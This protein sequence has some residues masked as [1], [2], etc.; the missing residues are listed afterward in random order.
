MAFRTTKIQSVAAADPEALYRQIAKT[1]A[2]PAYLW[3]HQQELLLGWHEHFRGHENVALELPT[4]AGKTLVGGLI[5]EWIRREEHKP[6]AYLCPTRQLAKQAHEKLVSYGISAVDLTGKSS[7]WPPADRAKFTSAQSVAVATYSHVFNAYP[8]IRDTGTLIFD[9]AHAGASYVSS[10][11]TVS[12]PR[13]ESLYFTLLTALSAGLDSATVE[14]LR[15]DGSS[16][17]N[18]GSVYLVSPRA[19]L[20]AQPQLQAAIAAD[21][22]KDRGYRTSMIGGN[23]GLCMV[24]ASHSKLEIR[25]LI[26]PTATH[27]AFSSPQRR[28]FMSATLGEGGELERSFGVPDIARMPIPRGWDKEG[29]GRRFFVFPA[30]T[31]ELNDDPDL[32]APWVK[33]TV[34]VHGRTALLTP[35]ATESSN[36]LEKSIP[37][38]FT[39]LSGHTVENDMAIFTNDEK[40]ILDLANRY[41]G[42]DLPNEACRLVILSGLP[43][44]S[45]L[46]EKFQYNSLG[47]QNVLQERIRTRL[48]QGMGRATRNQHDFSTVVVL[49]TELTN[50]MYR[51]EVLQA[52]REEIQAEI[53]FGR[54]E[55][56]GRDIADVNEN[57]AAFLAQSEAWSAVNAQI[58]TDRLMK[59]RVSPHGTAELA[60]AASYEVQAMDA[61]WSGDLESALRQ[62]RAVLDELARNPKTGRYA[63]LW[64]L[65]ACSWTQM[66]ADQRGDSERSLHRA[67]VK[68]FAN[69]REHARGT[70]WFR[71]LDPEDQD[72]VSVESYDELDRFAAAQIVDRIKAKTWG[73]ETRDQL[74]QAVRGLNQNSYKPFEGGLV[75]LGMLAGASESFG[76]NGEQAAPDAVWIFG[77]LLWVAWEAKSEAKPGGKVPAR[78][79][80]EASS[81]LT[82]TATKRTEEAPESSFICYVTPQTSAD[83]GA[84]AVAGEDVFMLPLH[85]PSTL[86]ARLEK[87]WTTARAMGDGVEVLTVLQALKQEGCLPSQWIAHYMRH[88]LKYFSMESVS[89]GTKAEVTPDNVQESTPA[90]AKAESG[91]E[92]G[93]HKKKA[94]AS[95]SADPKAPA[96]SPQDSPPNK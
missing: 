37:E 91:S 71:H 46:Q 34:E 6:V 64:F 4:G 28:I 27:D 16:L 8:K 1:N 61:L 32:L 84:M 79:S 21:G 14:S 85:E 69:V 49:G 12:V 80:R 93:I 96:T 51:P 5:A 43:T 82:F 90:E 86:L 10:A 89:G 58:A 18:D 54:E 2:G 23:L 56:L 30:V 7:G 3:G 9:D 66:L 95:P 38:G 42:V 24:Y 57:M 25:P 63:A 52:F 75:T 67:A 19:V 39:R 73:R 94:G 36:V 88:P 33:Q 59:K 35:S 13:S 72:G 68:H 45:D 70:T 48:V 78:Y 53:E 31:N 47:A 87:A 15:D 81:H 55:S 65:L 62:A 92:K 50:F 60:S 20:A 22:N 76:N 11:W 17:R 83:A 40:S 74:D 41:D 77:D 44:Q 26:C 29:T